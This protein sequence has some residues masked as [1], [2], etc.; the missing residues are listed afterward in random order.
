VSSS[1]LG[2]RCATPPRRCD[3]RSAYRQIERLRERAPVSRVLIHP[4]EEAR[5]GISDGETVRIVTASGSIMQ[6]AALTGDVDPRVAVAD[7]GWWFSEKKQ[8]RFGWDEANFNCLT[9]SAGPKDP[10]LG[11]IQLRALPCRL[12]KCSPGN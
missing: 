8:E 7:L 11:T 9:D 12:E 6:V 4:E 2:V 5:L 3:N 10:V 1:R